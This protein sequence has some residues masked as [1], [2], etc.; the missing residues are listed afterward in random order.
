MRTN[1]VKFSNKKQPEFFKDLRKRVDN[2]FH[3]RK[4]TKYTNA[5]MK[6]K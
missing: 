5:N 6:F 1:A 3:E 2:Y 4:F